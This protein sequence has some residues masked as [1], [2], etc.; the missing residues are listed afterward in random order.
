VN[1]GGVVDPARLRFPFNR[2]SAADT[3]DWDAIESWEAELAR[4]LARVSDP[5]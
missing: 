5:V 3:R 1:F 4:R 2:L